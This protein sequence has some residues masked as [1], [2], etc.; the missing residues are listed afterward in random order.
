MTSRTDLR[1]GRRSIPEWQ[2]D[3]SYRALS[4]GFRVR[5]NIPRAGILLDR[6]LAPFRAVISDEV[7]TYDLVRTNGERLPFSLYIDD[8]RIQEVESASSMLDFVLANVTVQAVELME[9]FV[10]F[11]AAAA[12]WDRR[13]IILPGQPDAGKTTLVAGLTQV[14]F[15]YLSD[16]AALIDPDT[17]L[18]HP[19]PRAL[20]MDSHSVDAIPGL[21]RKLPPDHDQFMKYR[22]HVAPDDL[23]PGAV[24]RPCRVQFVIAPRY[25]AGSVTALEPMSRAEAL[26]ML[27][28]NSF[29][30]VRFGG[31]AV[32]SL[33]QAMEGVRGY[34]LRVGSLD[35]AIRRVLDVVEGE[36]DRT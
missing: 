8:S 36:A 35:D 12:A 18:L 31:R 30:L 1:P 13:G 22:Y 17:G 10:S 32:E 19:F 14:G 29:N 23:R 28:E 2:F 34:R 5:T 6:L 24:G 26:M 25:E 16:E 7:P 11:H 9:D 15:A 27:A 21:R 20:A 4:Y 3:R 33:Q